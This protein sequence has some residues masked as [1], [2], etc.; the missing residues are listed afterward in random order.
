[1]RNSVYI[2]PNPSN[3]LVVGQNTSFLCLLYRRGPFFR[4]PNP[5]ASAGETPEANIIR[6]FSA[7]RECGLDDVG[8]Q[9]AQRNGAD[10]FVGWEV[11]F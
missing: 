9:D 7:G 5:S 11:L 4:R 3:R 2:V 8:N 10:C 1:M 6:Q